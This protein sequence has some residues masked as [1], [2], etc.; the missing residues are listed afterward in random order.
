MISSFVIINY[1]IIVNLLVWSFTLKL[2][3]Q[4][5]Y[6][7][8][9]TWAWV[10]HI[11]RE[12]SG[13]FRVSGEWSPWVVGSGL[14]RKW[15]VVGGSTD[16]CVDFWSLCRIFLWLE[17]GCEVTVFR[18]IL[19]IV[20]SKTKT[21]WLA[22]RVQ[23]CMTLLINNQGSSLLIMMACVFFFLGSKWRSVSTGSRQ[24]GCG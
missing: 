15:L 18:K 3:L 17:T 11:V 19:S 14:V 13:N 5:C 2:V 22:F 4:A 23:N 10:P 16:F 20:N 24:I 7:Y 12:L 8:H 9:L 21:N 6:E 1:E